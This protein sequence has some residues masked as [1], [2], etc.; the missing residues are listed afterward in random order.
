MIN[1]PNINPFGRVTFIE[2][3][4]SGVSFNVYKAKLH[5]QDVV[6]KTPLP[7]FTLNNF[8]HACQSDGDSFPYYYEVS[9]GETSTSSEN[10]LQIATAML[11][12]EAQVINWTAGAWNHS[13]IGM[14][15]WDVLWDWKENS[16]IDQRFLPVL[17]TPFHRAI[18]ISSLPYSLKRQLFPKMLSACWDALC[19]A[20]HGDLSESNLLI[21][22]KFDKFHIIDP[23]VSLSSTDSIELGNYVNTVCIFTTTAANYPIFPPFWNLENEPPIL[24]IYELLEYLSQYLN[25][26]NEVVGFFSSGRQIYPG[27]LSRLQPRTRP[28][29]PDLHALGI[30]YYRILTN[31]ELFLGSTV[32]PEKPA[33]QI[34]GY[35]YKEC[36]NL[37]SPVYLEQQL[38][39]AYITQEEKQLVSALLNLK[40]NTKEHLLSLVANIHV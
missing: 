4:H 16:S 26:S 21:S 29:I 27:S 6:L 36:L 38:S 13:V 34:Q 8:Y 12:A 3:L 24:N 20:H 28:S 10:P 32:L 14:G 19:I 40:V 23:G 30:I 37:L 1:F 33:W 2:L 11:L 25:Y 17:I 9:H 22:E 15:S 7:K 35:N 39:K 18:P 31:Q 5:N